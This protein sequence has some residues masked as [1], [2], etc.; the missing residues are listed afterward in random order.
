MFR[1]QG[2]PG[3]KGDGKEVCDLLVVFGNQV[4]IF[5]DKYC[6]LKNTG[7]LQT[8]WSRWYRAAVLGGAKQI[9]GAERWIKSYPDRIFLNN[10]CTQ[11]FPINLPGPA[12]AQ[13]HRIIVAHGAS[14]HCKQQLGGSGSL[15][16]GNNTVTDPL[17]SLANGEMPFTIGQVDPA[18]GFIHIF[19]DTTL[20]VIL[21]T[22]DTAPDFI[23]YLTKKEQF[24]TAGTFGGA[25]GEEELLAEYL[26][27]LNPQGEHDFVFPLDATRIYLGEGSW[28]A[29]Q[30]NPQ[31]LTQIEAN[32]ISYGWD[33][34]IEQFNGHQ[35]AGTAEYGSVS[36]KEI[37]PAI[38]FMA[39][40][41]R[42]S[43]RCLSMAFYDIIKKTPADKRAVRVITSPFL[44]KTYYVLMLFP[45]RDDLPYEQNRTVRQ[46][47]ITHYCQVVKVKFPNAQHILGI[48]T[49]SGQGPNRSEDFVYLDAREWTEELQAEALELQKE[50]NIL[51]NINFFP[52]SVQ[53][54]PEVN[55]DERDTSRRSSP[56]N[57]TPH[58]GR[59]VGRNQPCPCGSQI[60]YKF[61]CGK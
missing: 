9:W 10:S 23:A 44:D 40:E 2:Q 58:A 60:K 50:F 45:W 6:V 14:E 28:K 8:D 39:R 16:I 61:C 30:S 41:N 33:A 25:A 38:R 37:E 15:M 18:K 51:N 26:K 19:D 34:L 4:L 36:L 7:N 53:E 29:F 43:R 12:D 42:T 54:Y 31:R 52:I 11:P 3:K 46:N 21:Q 56:S 32:G 47:Q 49:E 22:L 17:P 20:D 57:R 1:D 35:L 55:S 59:K 27:K 48:A 5:S 24:F 13:Y